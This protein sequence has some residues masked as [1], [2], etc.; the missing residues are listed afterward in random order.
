[1]IADYLVE[2]IKRDFISLL[3]RGPQP[4]DNTL[5]VGRVLFCRL[6]RT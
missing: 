2:V 1:M 5:Q 4:L 6:C 3:S